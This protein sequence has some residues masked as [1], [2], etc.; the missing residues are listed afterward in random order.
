MELLPLWALRVALTATMATDWLAHLNGHVCQSQ[1]GQDWIRFAS[2]GINFI[3]FLLHSVLHFFLS[4]LKNNYSCDLSEAQEAQLWPDIPSVL[5][6]AEESFW[7]EVCF[8]LSTWIWIAR[9]INEAVCD[10]RNLEWG[11]TND[12]MCW[13]IVPTIN[14]AVCLLSTFLF[15]LNKVRFQ[16]KKNYIKFENNF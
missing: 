6:W 15:L 9:A 11:I 3:A 5:Q 10:A 16:I 8:R 7:R 13:Y 1:Y 14:H 2:V 4:H 12:Q